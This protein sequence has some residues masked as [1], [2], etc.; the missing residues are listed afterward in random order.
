MVVFALFDSVVQGHVH[1]FH[2]PTVVT[3]AYIYMP[4]LIPYRIIT[5]IIAATVRPSILISSDASLILELRGI[6]FLC[7]YYKKSY[8]SKP[9]RKHLLALFMY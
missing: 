2:L 8:I 9:M 4:A 7:P 6:C 1:C 5:N 3:R